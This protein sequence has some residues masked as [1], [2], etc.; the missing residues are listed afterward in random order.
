ML[1]PS[2]P[3]G[4]SDRARDVDAR[5]LGG[6]AAATLIAF[7]SVEGKPSDE[8]TPAARAQPSETA[9]SVPV[10]AVVKKTVPTFL[11][12]VGTTEAI[13]SV[14]VDTGAT[15]SGIPGPRLLSFACGTSL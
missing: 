9:L 5:L 1:G 2:A 13:R 7:Y 14:I 6:A 8:K 4:R 3:A 12:Y 15:L 11:D 10:K